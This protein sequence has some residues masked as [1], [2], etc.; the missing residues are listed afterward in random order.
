MFADTRATAERHDDQPPRKM[1]RVERESRI[2]AVRERMFGLLNSDERIPGAAVIE[3]SG[4]TAELGQL[5]HVPWTKISTQKIENIGTKITK[6]WHPKQHG[7]IAEHV[8]SDHPTIRR[9]ARLVS[10]GPYVYLSRGRDRNRASS[11]YGSTPAVA[12]SLLRR[13]GGHASRSRALQ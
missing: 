3:A 13:G 12:A 11:G 8:K 9:G 2:K 4:E 7:V 5:K 10:F 1:P 6:E